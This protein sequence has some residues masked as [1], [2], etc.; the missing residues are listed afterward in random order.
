MTSTLP[1]GRY[2]PLRRRSR[3]RLTS[4]PPEGRT[5]ARTAGHPPAGARHEQ[6]AISSGPLNS[7]PVPRDIASVPPGDG[8]GAPARGWAPP[9]QRLSRRRVRPY[10]RGLRRGDRLRGTLPAE[11]RTGPS[12]VRRR[13]IMATT[14]ADRTSVD[15]QR[16]VLDASTVRAV[17][18]SGE[19]ASAPAAP[20]R[21]AWL[22]CPARWP[23]APCRRWRRMAWPCGTCCPGGHVRVEGW[24]PAR[25]CGPRGAP[26]VRGYAG[27]SPCGDGCPEGTSE[28][29]ATAPAWRC[30][31]CGAADSGRQGSKV[32]EWGGVLLWSNDR[33]DQ[34]AGSAEGQILRV[35][36]RQS[37][38]DLRRR[39][40]SASASRRDAE[41]PWN[42]QGQATP[43]G[44]DGVPS[45]PMRVAAAGWTPW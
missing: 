19:Q 38:R 41:A 14:L 33:R 8:A 39:A 29:M 25:R 11:H 4:M 3:E 26:G 31:L 5:D 10:L 43:D 28:L 35:V 32:E 22:Q 27:R 42:R 6:D 24:C 36:P 2:L 12:R 21:L 16:R 45:V 37:L 17:L 34:L 23:G 7:S 44:H 20:T 40:G 9:P 18:V 15:A 30:G 1:A 13:L